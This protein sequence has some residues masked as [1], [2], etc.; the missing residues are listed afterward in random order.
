MR[1]IRTRYRDREDIVAISMSEI[2]FFFLFFCLILLGNILKLND[3]VDL[4]EYPETN[5]PVVIEGLEDRVAVLEGVVADKDAEINELSAVI[6][7]LKGE[8]E[9]IPNLEELL[10][11]VGDLEAEGQEAKESR[12]EAEA[13]LASALVVIV[14]KDEQISGLLVSLED[15]EA[16]VAELTGDLWN[17][18]ANNGRLTQELNDLRGAFARLEGENAGLRARLPEVGQSAVDEPI[19]MTLDED[20]GYTFASG[21][22]AI[23]TQFREAFSRQGRGRILEMIK[24]APIDIEAIE[25]I[26]HT[27]ED[28]SNEDRVNGVPISLDYTLMRA[29]NS[30]SAVSLSPCDNAGLGLSR[31][32]VTAVY[33]REALGTEFA[34][35]E[36]LPMSAGPLHQDTNR[37][38]TSVVPIQ[39]P[40]QSRRRIEVRLRSGTMD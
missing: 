4:Q 38:T 23:T 28:P 35:I 8:N 15:A 33:L 5:Y 6:I 37:V 17:S 26:G 34:G 19:F 39:T 13:K 2:V 3:P 24:N 22:N 12:E 18:E 20:D 36:I 9:G 11:K 40:D 16:E 30:P 31:A 14:E 32:V 1:S 27:D 7:I 29:L 21:S 10:A 25:V